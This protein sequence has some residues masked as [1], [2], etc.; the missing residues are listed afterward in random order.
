[1]SVKLTTYE[2]DVEVRRGNKH[3]QPFL[4]IYVHEKTVKMFHKDA[5]TPEQ[6]M[7]KCEKYGRP[8][9][10]RKMDVQKIDG[11]IGRLNLEEMIANPYED[12]VAMDEMVWRKRKDRIK[13]KGKDKPP[14]D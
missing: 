2:V 4:G 3:Y 5:R 10:V 12:A 11:D 8:L 7:Q 9:R 14:I 6:A 1:M 13:N